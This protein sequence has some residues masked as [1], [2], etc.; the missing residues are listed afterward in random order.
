MNTTGAWRDALLLSRP[1]ELELQSGVTPPSI[2][3]VNL[4]HSTDLFHDQ[5]FSSNYSSTR[6]RFEMDGCQA[7]APELD[8][9]KTELSGADDADNNGEG[10]SNEALHGQEAPQGKD[11]GLGRFNLAHHSRPP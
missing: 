8:Q 7:K 3:A 1:I 6:A 4:A 10:R 2:N 9:A 11:T 5:A